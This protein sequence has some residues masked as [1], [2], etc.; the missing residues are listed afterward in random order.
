LAEAL[1]EEVPLPQKAAADAVHIATAAYHGMH[2]LLTWNCTHIANVTLRSRIEFICKSAGFNAPLICT[3]QE[4]Q[5]P[6]DEK[7]WMTF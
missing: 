3:P 7:R 4:L 1:L 5:P 2:Y 6:E